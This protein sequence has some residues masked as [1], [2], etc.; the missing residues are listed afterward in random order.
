M[1]LT[2]YPR[3]PP[4]TRNRSRGNLGKSGEILVPRD[5]PVVTGDTIWGSGDVIL[6]IHRL[7]LQVMPCHTTTWLGACKGPAKKLKLFQWQCDTWLQNGYLFS[8]SK[9]EQR[10]RSTYSVL[11]S[12]YYLE[13]SEKL[14]SNGW[15]KLLFL[16]KKKCFY[17]S[18]YD[19]ICFQF[20]TFSK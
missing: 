4:M 18:L 13:E 14:F 15:I 2:P 12:S 17:T 10:L 8:K 9:A 19:I 6:G 7:Q 16:W 5:I 20:H 3:K 1:N 11:N